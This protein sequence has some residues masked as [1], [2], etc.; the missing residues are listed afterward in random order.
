MPF[1][2]TWM[3]LEVI[4][5]SEINQ[6]KTNTIRFH[7]YVEFKKQMNKEERQ[8]KPRLLTIENRGL[9]EGGGWRMGWMGDGY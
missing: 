2:T 9:I 6:K 5:P 7:S 8:A 4:M 3:D 1:T